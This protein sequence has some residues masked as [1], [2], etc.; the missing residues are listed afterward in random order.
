MQKF[1]N[2]DYKY[3]Q[4]RKVEE[5]EK[6]RRIEDWGKK[7]KKYKSNWL[8]KNPEEGLKYWLNQPRRSFFFQ[9][10]AIIARIVRNKV[11]FFHHK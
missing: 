7:T 5:V 6:S 2:K 3:E 1:D 8:S 4:Q 11:I 9:D 10:Y